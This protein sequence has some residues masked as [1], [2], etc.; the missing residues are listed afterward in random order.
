MIILRAK[1]LSKIFFLS[2]FWHWKKTLVRPHLSSLITAVCSRFKISN[3]SCNGRCKL[4]DVF[5]PNCSLKLDS[6]ALN[7]H[8]KWTIKAD[9][10]MCVCVLLKGQIKFWMVTLNLTAGRPGSCREVVTSL[11][12]SIIYPSCHLKRNSVSLT[13]I[14]FL[15]WILII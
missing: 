3:W 2:F 6:N 15:G 12:C 13:V 1:G 5:S 4:F 10:R 9:K 11:F 14:V 8:I 7:D